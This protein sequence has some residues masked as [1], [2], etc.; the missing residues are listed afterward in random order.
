MIALNLPGSL[1]FSAVAVYCSHTDFMIGPTTLGSLNVL[2][3]VPLPWRTTMSLAVAALSS[4]V[5]LLRVLAH[6]AASGSDVS[7][8]L[9]SWSWNIRPRP[10]AWSATTRKSSGRESFTGMPVEET[11]SSPRAKR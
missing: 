5:P 6:C 8:G 7:P 4:G 3:S 2:G 9:P 11:T 10:S 1:N